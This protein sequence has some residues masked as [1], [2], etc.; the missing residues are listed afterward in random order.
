M[1]YI[2]SLLVLVISL[3]LFVRL[4]VARWYDDL[5]IGISSLVIGTCSLFGFRLNIICCSIISSDLFSFGRISI[6]GVWLSSKMGL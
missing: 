3:Y 4:F 6:V 1:V 5:G 2:N